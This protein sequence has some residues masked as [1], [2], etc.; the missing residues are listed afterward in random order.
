MIM[1]WGHKIAA[2]YILFAC[3]IIFLVVQSSRQKVDLVEKDYY[4]QELAYQNR[5]NATENARQL[6]GAVEVFSS[7]GK[8]LILLPEEMK[9]KQAEAE[10]YLYCPSD[11]GKDYKKKV[12]F[13]DRQT[14]LELPA[15]LSGA[16]TL[17][18]DW[19]AGGKSYYY[20]ENLFL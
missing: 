16:F 17:K 2:F 7:P 13:N 11:A 5:I 3:G 14:E 20:Q 6:K 15:G 8:L 19:K 4:E 18:L 10:V 9:G 12:S 1:N